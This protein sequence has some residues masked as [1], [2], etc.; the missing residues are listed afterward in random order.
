MKILT[1]RFQNLNSLQGEWLIDFRHSAYANEGI[2]AITGPTGA[3]KSTILDA[4]CLALYGA[5]PRLG[6]IT[7]TKND[8]MSRQTG[9]CYAEVVFTSASGSYCCYWGQKRA[10]KKPDGKLQSPKHELAEYINDNK[11]G[12]ILEEKAK[13]TKQKIEQITGMDYQRFTRSMLLAQGSFANFLQANADERA[14]ILEQ[15]TGTEIYSQISLKVHER[16][17]EEKK[18][19]D[20][21]MAKL[22]GVS[23]L[24]EKDEQILIIEKRNLQKKVDETKQKIVDIEQIKVLQQQLVDAKQQQK[25]LAVDKSQINYAIETF[26]PKKQ[27]LERAQK[28]LE[29]SGDYTNLTFVRETKQ[30]IE[31]NL[32][33]LQQQQPKL[34]H[35]YQQGLQ[36]LKV[37]YQEFQQAEQIWQQFQ[38]KLE[39]AR[40]LDEQILHYKKDIQKIEEHIKK[41]EEQQQYLKQQILEIEQ[42]QIILQQQVQQLLQFPSYQEIPKVLATLQQL[43]KRFHELNQQIYQNIQEKEQLVCQQQQIEKQR[44]ELNPKIQDYQKKHQENQVYLQ[45]IDDECKKLLLDKSVKELQMQYQMYD[46]IEQ[47]STFIINQYQQWQEYTQKYHGIEE[48]QKSI[49]EQRCLVNQKI[50]RLK[51]RETYLIEKEALLN[52]KRLLLVKIVSLQDERQHLKS[53]EPCPLCGATQHP[54]MHQ[55]PTQLNET[56]QDYQQ[57][58]TQLKQLLSQLQEYLLQENSLSNYKKENQKKQEKYQQK[59]KELQEIIQLPLNQLTKLLS[60]N[61]EFQEFFQKTMEFDKFIN[62]VQ[63]KNKEK[64]S[65]IS[66]KLHLIKHLQEDL[67]SYQQQDNQ[68]KELLNSLENKLSVLSNNEQNLKQRQYQLSQLQTQKNN[69]YQLLHEEIIELI[70]PYQHQFMLNE[71]INSETLEKLFIGLQD[72]Y[73]CWQ[74][75][76]QKYKESLSVIDNNKQELLKLTTNLQNLMTNLQQDCQ[77]IMNLNLEVDKLWESRLQVL[78]DNDV[79]VERNRLNELKKVAYNLWQEQQKNQQI[80]ESRWQSC[81]LQIK[82]LNSIF[83]EQSLILKKSEEDF[84]EKL[85]NRGFT[86]EVDYQDS[87]LMKSERINLQNQLDSLNQKKQHIYQK[88]RE[89]NELVE[90]LSIKVDDTYSIEY[91][92][93]KIEFLNNDLSEKQQKIGAINQQLDTNIQLKNNYQSLLGLIE[94]QRHCYAEWQHLHELI[95]S[96]DGKKYRNFAQGL[97]FEVM[98][99]YANEQLQKMSDRYLLMADTEHPLTL[100]V[101]D[102]YQ[103]GQVRTSKNLSGGESFIISLALALGLSNMASHRMQVDS[104]FLDEGF[105]TLDDDALDV[106]LDTLTTLQQTGKLIGIISHI[107]ALKERITSQ[108]QVIPITGGISKIVG[109][110]CYLI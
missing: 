49:D 64:L 98:I 27:Q 21:L 110:G 5:T 43:K 12:K 3:G 25:Q 71:E 33:N 97:T 104:L 69:Q 92:Q 91:L 45:T 2:F 74:E 50:E 13:K 84:I 9:E 109:E 20:E 48:E 106:A 7:E 60:I 78:S 103:G 105:G 37:V 72:L 101:L 10:Y 8:I 62:E 100:N 80:L 90:Q 16:K 47:K 46:E 4:I 51:E 70:R 39:Q 6:D 42:Q 1:L 89:I 93:N 52:E 59:I 53:G 85:F 96:S 68:L 35:E 41:L 63:Q 18:Q 82:E 28:A 86:D 61:I 30:K 15:I 32:I 22:S 34:E 81:C 14:P 58:K 19:L 36:Q 56:M 55:E 79:T 95:G 40:F 77:K 87:C 73:K 17:N 99:A 24:S 83:V 88:Y 65:E 31:N 102:N 44:N 29:I 11:K 66:E 23:P 54:F 108:I 76:E 57:V 26:L 94:Q 67:E 107:Q 75:N 38:P